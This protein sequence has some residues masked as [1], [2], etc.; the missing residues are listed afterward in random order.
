MI[1]FLHI[2]VLS[3]E[4]WRG[5][6]SGFEVLKSETGRKPRYPMHASKHD[7]MSALGDYKP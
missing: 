6:Y 7:A 1:N 5:V 3:F 2:T 4:T